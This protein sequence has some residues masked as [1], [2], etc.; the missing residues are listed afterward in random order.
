MVAFSDRP[1]PRRKIGGRWYQSVSLGQVHAIGERRMTPPAPDDQEL[2]HQHH[3]VTVLAAAQT[4]LPVRFGALT[5]RADLQRTVAPH[6]ETLRRGLEDVRDRVQ[7]NVRFTGTSPRPAALQVTAGSG[8]EYLERR[9]TSAALLLS[10]A[11]AVFL[12]ALE[13]VA[14]RHRIEPGSGSLIA[15]AYHLV[16]HDQLSRYLEVA[17]DAQRVGAVVTGPYPP[18][19]FTPAIL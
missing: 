4:I 3:V 6:E 11:A 15:T 1:W 13:R 17:G 10:P 5:T 9:R 19:A 16:P 7:M 12:A 18:F 8:R 2:R 14:A